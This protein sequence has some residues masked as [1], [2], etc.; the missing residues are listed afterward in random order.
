MPVQQAAPAHNRARPPGPPEAGART[1]ATTGAAPPGAD[2][3]QS[4]FSLNRAAFLV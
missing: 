1:A 3:R 4:L 2:S